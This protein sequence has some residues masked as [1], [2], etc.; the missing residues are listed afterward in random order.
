MIGNPALRPLQDPRSSTPDIPGMYT[1][2]TRQ[3][4]W[5]SSSDSWEKLLGRR[6]RL[7]AEA[8]R[9]QQTRQTLQDGGVVVDDT[10]DDDCSCRCAGGGQR[11][12]QG[13]AWAGVVL[14]PRCG[15]HER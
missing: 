10:D 3:P 14:G 11:E 6:E 12:E 15:R 7:N 9:L 13:G 1:S 5:P 4:M 2:M 8:P